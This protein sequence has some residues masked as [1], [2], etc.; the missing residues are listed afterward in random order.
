MTQESSQQTD[1]TGIRR[2]A[3]HAGPGLRIAQ[4][5][6]SDG[7]GGAEI[8]MFQLAEELRLRGHEVVHIGPQHGVGWLGR[9]FRDAGF[10]S[11]TFQLA[12]PVDFACLRALTDTLARHRIDVVHSHEFTMCVYGSAAARRLGIPHVTTMHGNETMMAR[13]R[14][15]VALRWSFRRSRMVVACSDATRRDL[16]SR[17][18]LRAGSVH[19]IRNG[20][21]ELSGRRMP[22]RDEL[23][24][25]NHE[26][27]IACVGNVVPRKGH[28]QLLQAL[29][30]AEEKHGALPWRVA[31]AGALRDAVP[32]IQGFIARNGWEQRVHLLG[33]RDDVPDLLAAAD[34]F[35][36]P[37]L[38]EGL[39]LALL[40]AMFA[41]LPIV[42][43]R[44]SGI[45]E[46]ID[47]PRCG[48][49][50][51]PGDVEALADQLAQVLRDEALRRSL[52]QG[53]R[54]RA[55]AEFT[56]A[57]MTDRYLAAYQGLRA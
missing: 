11:D 5:L 15:R 14:R 30:R 34:V 50:S 35:A 57:V 32:G 42:A 2:D 24:L 47:S 29:A 9:R 33:A 52:G 20:V 28:L 31:I 27:L 21:P 44:V 54:E 41:S 12:R 7:P 53:A 46:A 3:A 51:P 17:L 25:S 23:G 39:P 18:G 40:E 43:S 8:V 4:M 6:E 13:L 38:W 22:I 36:M 48:L 19:T 49:L 55:L 10:V 1:S 26:L 56:V 37:S 16:E 45:P